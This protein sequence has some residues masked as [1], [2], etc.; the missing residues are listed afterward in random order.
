MAYCASRPPVGEDGHAV[1]HPDRLVDVVGHQHH[2]L[3]ELGLQ[4][5]ELVLQAAPHDRVD[6]AEGLVHQQ[7]RR[8]GGQRTGD[9]DALPLTAGELVG[10]APGVLLRVEPDGVEQLVGALAGG[11]LRLA[12][13]QR[14]G[15]HVLLD[16][17]VGEQP[18]LL[19]DVADAAAQLDRVG[20]GDVLAVEPDPAG[21]GLDEP[22]DHLERRGLAAARRADE[23][24][25]LAARDVEVEL[26]DGDGPVGVGLAD[27][28]EPDHRARRARV[29]SMR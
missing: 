14:D 9:A 7:H 3:A 26:V 25:H 16:A 28:L 23:A 11:R 8:V 29:A 19:D 5:A 22:V 10:V 4:P 27:A 1:A 6:G 18:D 24:D 15:H 17:L 12:V 2:G 13:E 20:V 21:G